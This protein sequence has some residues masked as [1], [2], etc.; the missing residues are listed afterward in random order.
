MAP[1]FTL[2]GLFRGA[3]SGYAVSAGERVSCTLC[4]PTHGVFAKEACNDGRCRPG[5]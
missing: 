4:H 3:R 1:V 2:N 5:G